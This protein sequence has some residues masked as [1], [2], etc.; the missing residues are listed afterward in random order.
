MDLCSEDTYPA[1][2]PTTHSES[3]S[4]WDVNLIFDG[5]RQFASHARNGFVKII[6][7]NVQKA[8]AFARIVQDDAPRVEMKPF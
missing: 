4:A 8:V 5:T 3:H 1:A 2:K 6:F 7:S